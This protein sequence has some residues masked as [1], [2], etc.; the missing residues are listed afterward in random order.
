MRPR[1]HNEVLPLELLNDRLIYRV[2]HILT[3]LLRD[4]L[5]IALRLALFIAAAIFLFSL[6]TAAA[7]GFS[8]LL[9]WRLLTGRRP[10]IP[11]WQDIFAAHRFG[12]DP[13]MR[14]WAGVPSGGADFGGR[15]PF[16]FHG[17]AS[18]H[19]ARPTTAAPTDVIDAEVREVRD[20][21]SPH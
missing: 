19:P 14:A 9:L 12:F 18:S 10:V 5:A 13:R 11:R 21:K 15:A 20:P 3:D 8:G 7:L 2:M 17:R 16:S 6:I 4:L 1:R